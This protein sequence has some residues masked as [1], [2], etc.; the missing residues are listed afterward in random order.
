MVDP[1]LEPVSIVD[2]DPTWAARYAAEAARLSKALMPLE[3]LV[4]HIGSTAVPL[5]AKPIID[6]QIA[7]SEHAVSSAVRALVE[8]GFDHHGEL[9]VTGRQYLTRRGTED[10]PVNVHIFSRGSSLLD[11]NRMIRDHL[12][13]H[14]DAARRYED[15]KRRAI[16][17]GH[18]DLRSYSQAKGPLVAEI[19]ESAYHWLRRR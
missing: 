11:D 18:D 16:R 15:V 13:A 9:G 1:L 12:R 3:S 4:E 5:A 10:Q 8:L 2:P 7:V 14:P 17:Q 19:Q 6:V